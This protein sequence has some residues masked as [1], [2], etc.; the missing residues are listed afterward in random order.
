MRSGALCWIALLGI[1]LGVEGAYAQESPARPTFKPHRFDE[2]WR[3]LCDPSARTEPLDRVK[4]VPLGG[5][6]TL[7]IG[8][9]LRERF[10][11]AH[12]PRFGLTQDSDSAFLHRAL[13]H[14]DLRIGDLQFGTSARGF[15]QFGYFDQ[16][17]RDLRATPTD[18]DRLDVT[19]AFVDLSAEALGGRTTLRGGRQE[20]SFG[21]S[22]LVSVREGPNVRRS[23]DG[24]RAFWSDGRYRL[25]GFYVQPV[26]I[27][28][29]TFDDG[30]DDSEAFWGAYLTGPIPGN[31]VLRADLYYL[32]YERQGA[33]F[34]IGVADERRHTIGARL[35]GAA[36]GFDWDVEAALQFGDFGARDIRAWTIASDVG[37][38]FADTPLSPRIGL[39]A[40]IA[41][42]DDDP[43]DGRLGTFNALYPKLPYFSE[44]NLVAPANIVDVHPTLGLDLGT[45][46]TF[47]LGWNALW[48]QTTADAIYGTPLAAIADTA[49]STGR[50]IGHQS[51]VGMTWQVTPSLTVSGDYVHFEPG[52][53]LTNAGGEPVDFATLSAAFRF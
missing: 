20:L 41:S 27:E 6:T 11:A 7:T 14:T 28:R 42:G 15:V 48:R 19:Q 31:A 49:G 29:G 13:L 23:F 17:G 46:V 35:F 52:R 24:G 44:A 3:P 33:T 5:D 34:A 22:R 47:E 10:E 37:Y 40:D 45:G 30:T 12:N 50:F 32:G 53:A 39:K 21:S 51:I 26:A 8:G 25:D 38:T 18:V 1:A 43:T 36:G 4:C 2:D 16:S 9:E